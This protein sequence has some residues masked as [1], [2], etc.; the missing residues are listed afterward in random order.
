[1]QQERR[2]TFLTNHAHVL[3]ALAR[4]PD[5]R[6]QDIAAQTGISSRA[7]LSILRDLEDAGYV[8]RTREGRRT[9]YTIHPDRPLRHP[10]NASHDVGELIALLA[11]P[12]PGR[13]RG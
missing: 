5:P 11:E 12:G 13:E 1:M 9:R 8:H 3:L 6:V 7:A 4:A 10:T 2:W